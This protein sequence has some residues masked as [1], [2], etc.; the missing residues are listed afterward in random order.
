LASDR[1]D[2]DVGEAIAADL[3]DEKFDSGEW[4]RRVVTFDDGVSEDEDDLVRFVAVPY[5]SKPKP[6]VFTYPKIID[7]Q[8]DSVDEENYQPL[9]FWERAPPT[10]LCF[11]LPETKEIIRESVIWGQFSDA[12]ED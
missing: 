8:F 3:V 1:Y 5:P 9:E 10:M 7:G 6:K 11:P 4:D 12:E 2:D